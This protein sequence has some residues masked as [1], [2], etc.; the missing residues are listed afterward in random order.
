L[1]SMLKSGGGS[2]D[3]TGNGS[4]RAEQSVSETS[5]TAGATSDGAAVQ[6]EFAVPL[7]PAAIVSGDFISHA[8]NVNSVAMMTTDGAHTLGTKGAQEFSFESLYVGPWLKRPKKSTQSDHFELG[9][10]VH[11]GWPVSFSAEGPEM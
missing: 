6:S 9:G 8:R 11:S 3:S 7:T 5:G 2:T 4:L 10:T 1:L